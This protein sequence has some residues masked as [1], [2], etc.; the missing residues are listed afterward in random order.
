MLLSSFLPVR[1][2][3]PVNRGLGF[4]LGIRSLFGLGFSSFLP[5]RDGAGSELGGLTYRQ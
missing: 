1:D 2:G 3:A 4:R 5:V